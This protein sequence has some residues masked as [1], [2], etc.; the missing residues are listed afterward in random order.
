MSLF[1]TFEGC[2]GFGKS[3]QA[4][5]LYQR[6]ETEGNPS[7]LTQEP[8]GTVVGEKISELL[9]WS[10]SDAIC[11][12][13][14]VM[15]FNASRA[16]LVSRVIKPALSTGLVVVCDRYVDSTMV[17]Q[18]YGRGLNLSTVRAINT[19]ATQGLMP[20]LSILLDMPVE[21][22]MERKHGMKADR[23]EKEGLDF[24]RKVRDGYLT[25]A[26]AEPGRWLVVDASLPKEKIA[27]IIWEKVKMALDARSIRNT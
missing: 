22:G 10:E 1:I 13:A 9:K 18:G 6:L 15:L 12:L 21:K 14:E 23:F 26:A 2:E 4:K 8:G 3:S 16:E 20:D 24:H 7:V 27:S 17:Y 19:I 25:L 11:P 5:T